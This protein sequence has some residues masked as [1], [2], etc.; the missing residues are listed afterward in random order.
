ML[1]VVLLLKVFYLKSF[2]LSQ[3]YIMT[4]L[5]SGTHLG[6]AT[7]FFPFLN[8]FRQLRV[9]CCDAPSL[10]RGQVCSFQLLRGLAR[11]MA[12]HNL[13]IE[14]I[15]KLQ[16]RFTYLSDIRTCNIFDLFAVL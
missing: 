13:I 10:K 16:L 11:A 1:Q 7:N 5:A 14:L 2:A 4:D 6:P 12:I 8:D 9:G 15:L 3:S